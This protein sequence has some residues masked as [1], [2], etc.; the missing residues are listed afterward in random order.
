[1]EHAILVSRG[2]GIDVHSAVAEPAGFAAFY[3]LRIDA[4][5]NTVE[6]RVAVPGGGAIALRRTPRCAWFR[7]GSPLAELEGASDVDLPITPLT[8]T[9]PI[10]RLALAPGESAAIT[11]AYIDFPSLAV[12]PDRQ[13]YTR[14]DAARYRFESV[15]GDFVR[16]IE[17]D[18]HG[19]V[20]EYPGMF[21]RLH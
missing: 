4:A 10:R 2:G 9:L 5:W 12:A 17:V 13:R 7:E 14:L 16:E 18:E 8:N 11:V 21:R 3:F 15:D 19:L 20:V 6:V 1:M